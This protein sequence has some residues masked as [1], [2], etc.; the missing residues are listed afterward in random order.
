[1][2]LKIEV[3]GYGTGMGSGDPC[4]SFKKSLA[5]TSVNFSNSLSIAEK[6]LSS[7]SCSEGGPS[8]FRKE[9]RRCSTAVG[10][11]DPPTGQLFPKSYRQLSD[12]AMKSS[13]TL[14]EVFFLYLA[15]FNCLRF[16][17]L[18]SSIWQRMSNRY[19]LFT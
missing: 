1:T 7:L 19:S 4:S 12:G 10:I 18:F 11:R 5:F 8:N 13:S 17:L 16:T 15:P 6:A 14:D 9:S 2:V 3:L